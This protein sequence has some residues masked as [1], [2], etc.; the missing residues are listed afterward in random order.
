MKILC[1]VGPNCK[2]LFKYIS[3]GFSENAE[4]VFLSGYYQIDETNFSASYHRL[5]NSVTADFEIQNEDI[6]IIERC[7][8]L[9]SLDKK[10][11]LRHILATRICINQVLDSFKP[12][13]IFSESIDQFL[14]DILCSEAKKRDIPFI[15]LIRTFVNGYIRI[16]SKGE[17]TIIRD[18]DKTEVDEVLETLLSNNYIPSNLKSIKTNLKRRYLNIWVKNLFKVPF[19][20]ICRLLKFQKY[21]YHFWA[22]IV[23]TK[24]YYFHLFPK[25]SIGSDDWQNSLI[26]KNKKIIF[27]PLQHVPEATVDYWC[28][29]TYQIR[30]EEVLFKLISKLGDDYTI[31]IKEHPGVLGFRKPKF[32]SKLAVQKNVVLCPTYV[33]AQDCINKSDAILVWTGSIGF[34]SLLRGK[35]VLTLSIPYYT[36]GVGIMKINLDTDINNITQF[37]SN[38]AKTI[39]Q[40]DCQENVTK[41][42]LSGLFKGTFRNDGTFSESS[43]DHIDEAVKLGNQLALFYGV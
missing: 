20:E 29:D 33:S 8:L 11:A 40:R 41:Y 16:S 42:L 10:T 23:V 26:E 25:L 43:K 13:Y 38:T 22:T 27:I 32:Y 34:E 2:D 3:K 14:T 28:D 19:F 9:R 36:N 35:P 17:H 1:H 15:G 7:R 4:V 30:Y 5:V 39:V 12:E 21:N 6:D 24:K 37:I 18:P 31:L